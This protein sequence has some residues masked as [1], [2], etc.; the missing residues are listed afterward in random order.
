M[1]KKKLPYQKSSLLRILSLLA[2]FLGLILFLAQQIEPVPAQSLSVPRCDWSDQ[3][4][5][6]FYNPPDISQYTADQVGEIL[7]V[8]HI[9]TF[10]ADEVANASDLPSTPYGAEAYRILYLSQSPL[11]ELEVVSGL[12]IVPTGSVPTA[13]FPVIAHGHGTTGMA[14]QCAPSQRILTVWDLVAWVG[15][16]YVVT[17]TDYAGLG[18]PG[19]H[20]YGVG[21]SAAR[22][23][24]DSGRAARNFCDESRNIEF[25]ADNRLFLEG[26]S[27]GGHSALFAHQVWPGYAPELNV[28]GTV[29]FAPGAELR[30]LAQQTAVNTWSARIAPLSLAMLAYSQYYG[31]PATLD[32]WL[33][34]PFAAELPNRAENQCLVGLAGWFGFNPELVF[35][36]D[37]LAAIVAED[38]DALQPWTTYI[39]LN[40]PGNYSSDVP[41]LIQQGELDALIPP[42]VSQQLTERLCQNDTPT[43]LNRF[44][45]LGHSTIV[46]QSRFD[47]L[48]WMAARLDGEPMADSCNQTAPPD[49]NRDLE[50]VIV[51]GSDLP[52]F[53]NLPLGDLFVV[54]YTESGWHLIPFQIDEVTETGEYT[55]SEDGYLD[56]NDEI[57][58]MAKDV[59]QQSTPGTPPNLLLPISNFW[60]EIKATN[61]IDPEQEGWVYLVHAPDWGASSPT[62]YVHFDPLLRRIETESYTVG[63]PLFRPSIDYL[64]LGRNGVDILD[65]TKVFLDCD[66]P[67]LCPV[68]EDNLPPATNQSVVKDGP[69][70]LI[71]HEGRVLGYGTMMSWTR[72]YSISQT[73]SG[74]VRVSTDFNQAITGALYYSAVLPQGVSVDGLPDAVLASPMSDWWQISTLDGSLIEVTDVTT[75]GGTPANYYVDDANTD[76]DD[77]GDQRHYGD[78]GLAITNPNHQFEHRFTWYMLPDPQ[79][80]IGAAYSAFNKQ[81]ISVSAVFQL[82]PLFS[83]LYLPNVYR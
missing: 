68:T 59:G 82:G 22:S 3:S 30:L 74:D 77:T 29:V 56:S 1:F 38:W 71:L 4:Y 66:M 36:P 34:Q 54:A 55:V 10:T 50:P 64:A 11:D 16:G 40:T 21:E 62:D 25:P 9:R 42:E 12:I 69:V 76:P 61:P 39:D 31:A 70:R 78:S 58:F 32:P 37:L 23:L 65:R 49:L 35:Q 2:T 6:N 73:L 7:R 5:N 83:H 60:Y 27:Q 41:V 14:D 57:V 81:P 79:P 28:L 48:A 33:Q 46:W 13:G 75:V 19:L 80:N 18:T 67:L 20:P 43:Q 63:F 8:E 52:I 51:T 15:H 26:H 24:L 53:D 44:A 17:A 72:P 45:G 47:A